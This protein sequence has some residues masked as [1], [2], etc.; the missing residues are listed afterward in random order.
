MS[1]FRK[2]E[3]DRFVI[4]SQLEKVEHDSLEVL[5]QLEKVEDFVVSVTNKHLIR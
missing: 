3:H 2:V 5:F 1:Q 4:M